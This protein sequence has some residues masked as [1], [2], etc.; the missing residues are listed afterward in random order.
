LIFEVYAIFLHS[1]YVGKSEKIISS[2]P[3]L[4]Y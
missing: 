4:L 2:A 3:S 1:S